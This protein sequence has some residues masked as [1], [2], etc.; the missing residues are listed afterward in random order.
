[1]KKLYTIILFIVFLNIINIMFVALNIFPTTYESDLDVN[2][3]SQAEELYRTWSGGDF[4]D[5]L[6]IFFGKAENIVALFAGLALSVVAAWITH[7][8]APFVVGMIGTV[9]LTLYNSTSGIFA[10]YPINDYIMLLCS[11]GMIILFIVTCAEY[12]TH[13][14]V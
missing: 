8:P 3:T 14:D 10:S 2:E 7:S 4:G 13:G 12:L 1:M 5:M 9:F 6:M 11:F